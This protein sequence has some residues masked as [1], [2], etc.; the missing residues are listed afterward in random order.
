MMNDM[1]PSPSFFIIRT[2]STVAE[3]GSSP[4][5]ARIVPLIPADVLPEWLEI[6]AYPRSLTPAQTAGMTSLGSF[7]PS[8]KVT[9]VNLTE[10]PSVPTFLNT[11]RTPLPSAAGFFLNAP[12]LDE[13]DRTGKGDSLGGR[14]KSWLKSRSKKAKKDHQPSVLN[15]TSPT[16]VRTAKRRADDEDSDGDAEKDEVMEACKFWVKYGRCGVYEGPDKHVVPT[17]LAGLAEFGLDELPMWY[18]RSR[19]RRT[20]AARVALGTRLMMLRNWR[21]ESRKQ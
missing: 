2:G 18:M 12:S 3:G 9:V 7:G 21:V 11:R 14:N 4:A 19:G 5:R 6:K 1:P 16:T 17:T 10:T 13:E 8:D 20:S 15:P